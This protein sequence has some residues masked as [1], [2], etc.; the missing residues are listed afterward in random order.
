MTVRHIRLPFLPGAGFES[1][2][3]GSLINRYTNCTT[4]PGQ[5]GSQHSHKD[6]IWTFL[7]NALA[8]YSKSKTPSSMPHVGNEV[9][10]SGVGSWPY[11]ETL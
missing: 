3:F 10:H 9:L 11:P 8:Y 2:T 5:I 7:S 1:M 4:A 6:E